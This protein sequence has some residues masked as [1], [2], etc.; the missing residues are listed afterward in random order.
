MNFEATPLNVTTMLLVAFAIYVLHFL[1]KK[2]LDSNL[3][4]LFYIALLIFMNLTGRSLSPYLFAAGV[5]LALLLRF[6]FL[7]GTFTKVIL[8]LEM[9]AVAGIA[10]KFTGD[11]LGLRLLCG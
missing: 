2:K 7:N 5:S 4:L 1:V 9:L 11:I 6:E 3:P 10:V 8:F